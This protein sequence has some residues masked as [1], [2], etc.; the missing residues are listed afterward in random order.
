M[1][2][3]D[4]ISSTNIPESLV[5][6]VV[7]QVGGWASFQESAQDIARYGADT[8]VGGFTYY[9]ETVPFAKRHRAEMMAMAEETARDCY[10]RG[11]NAFTLIAGFNCLSRRIPSGDVARAI[12]DRNDVNATDVYNALAW[13]ALEE[14]ARAYCDL[15]D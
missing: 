7:R 8:G 11:A 10:G 1:K 14:T 4:F 6:A 13:Y 12:Y 15:T 9:A 3:K 5:R 2:L